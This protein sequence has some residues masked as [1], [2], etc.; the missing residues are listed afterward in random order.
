MSVEIPRPTPEFEPPG[1]G[2]V[3]HNFLLDTPYKLTPIPPDRSTPVDSHT[4]ISIQIFVEFS[5]SS[6]SK[7]AHQALTGR[8]FSNRVVVVSYFEPEK[9]HRKEFS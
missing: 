3:Q 8:K 5:S 2:K 7:V 1:C 6:E 4:S 9:Y